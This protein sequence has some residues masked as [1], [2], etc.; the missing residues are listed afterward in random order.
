MA[1]RKVDPDKKRILMPI[2]IQNFLIPKI[3]KIAEE[4]HCSRS[5]LIENIIAAYLV[6][7]NILKVE[8]YYVN[9]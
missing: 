3:N 9:K 7:E 1:N 6:K 2:T 5:D 4:K 8:E